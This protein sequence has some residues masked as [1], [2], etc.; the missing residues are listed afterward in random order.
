MLL[1]AMTSSSVSIDMCQSLLTVRTLASV[2]FS[3]R[4]Q[5][6]FSA[7]QSLRLCQNIGTFGFHQSPMKCRGVRM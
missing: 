5:A 6:M 2:E 3:F 1:A 4:C 7:S